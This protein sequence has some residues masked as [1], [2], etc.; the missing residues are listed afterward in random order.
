MIYVKKIFF[1]K[2][3]QKNVYKTAYQKCVRVQKHV[4]KRVQKRVQKTRTKNAYTRPRDGFTSGRLTLCTQPPFLGLH[5]CNMMDA[6]PIDGPV[7]FHAKK[8]HEKGTDIYI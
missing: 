4:Q 5:A 7:L 2:C 8:L 3:V 6:W 1:F